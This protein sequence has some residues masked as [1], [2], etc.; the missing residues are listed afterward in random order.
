MIF[1]VRWRRGEEKSDVYLQPFFG[2]GGF[3][4][5]SWVQGVRIHSGEHRAKL[6]DWHGYGSHKARN[7]VISDTY[8]FWS[9]SSSLP[10]VFAQRSLWSVAFYPLTGW[11]EHPPSTAL[12]SC[13][14]CLLPEVWPCRWQ[15]L[16]FHDCRAP[17]F[18]QTCRKLRASLLYLFGFKVFPAWAPFFSRE[19]K[20]QKTWSVYFRNFLWQ[21]AGSP[22]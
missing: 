21:V 12:W 19:N 4:S 10:K 14:R 5:T 1:L 2:V 15:T 7:Q 20:L 18:N 6:E 22:F 13:Q 17:I 8:I 11:Y 16:V 9:R 3:Q